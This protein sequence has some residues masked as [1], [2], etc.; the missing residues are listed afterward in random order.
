MDGDGR[1]RGRREEG[2]EAQL[3]ARF[4]IWQKEP[5]CHAAFQ[6]RHERGARGRE[7]SAQLAE[8]RNSRGRGVIITRGSRNLSTTLLPTSTL[9]FCQWLKYRAADGR[10]WQL[11]CAIKLT[12]PSVQPSVIHPCA[13]ASISSSLAAKLDDDASRLLSNAICFQASTRSH[14]MNRVLL[15][16]VPR[17]SLFQLL[18]LTGQQ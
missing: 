1:G 6:P 3:L 4:N 7:G 10:K 17:L 5:I 2:R 9:I 16:Q 12:E 14:N 13:C 11:A 15:L 8:L 18:N